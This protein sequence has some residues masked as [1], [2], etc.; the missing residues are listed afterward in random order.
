LHTHKHAANPGPG[1]LLGI[2]AR[3]WE[4]AEICF[5]Y[6]RPNKNKPEATQQQSS[7]RWHLM[8]RSVFIISTE[9]RSRSSPMQGL[10][11]W[12]GTAARPAWHRTFNE[13]EK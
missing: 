8:M 11:V 9:R 10:I 4:I 13:N 3:R 6:G 12:A 1:K 2:V 5:V 7:Q